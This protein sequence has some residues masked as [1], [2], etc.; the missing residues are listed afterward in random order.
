MRTKQET[1]DYVVQHLYKQGKPAIE[2]DHCRYRT[3]DGLMCAAG[4]LIHDNV[5]QRDFEKKPVQTLILEGYE[6]P[7]EFHE[8]YHML[9][10][11]QRIHDNWGSEDGVAYLN[12][13]LPECAIDHGVVFR[14]PILEAQ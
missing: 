8:Y 12:K 3:S 9:T 7:K 10:A 2:G 13:Y 4:C 11:L 5:Y 6:V 14:N 1:F